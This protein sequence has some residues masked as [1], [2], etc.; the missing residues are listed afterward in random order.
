MSITNN[1]KRVVIKADQGDPYTNG[2]WQES[3]ALPEYASGDII[4]LFKV[5]KNLYPSGEGTGK[6]S[7]SECAL[8]LVYIR[9]KLGD[10]IG[11]LVFYW[12]YKDRE[13]QYFYTKYVNTG[14][15]TE[16]TAYSFVGHF[17]NEVN[18]PGILICDMAS[19]YGIV[20]FTWTIV[21]SS[22]L[23]ISLIWGPI[24]YT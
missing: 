15:Y 16:G 1:I 9:A 12:H 17:D 24:Q 3:I 10:V 6:V 11:D 21:D 8:A 2:N 7:E 19:K 13:Y 4:D 20:R 23:T 18:R 14:S 5:P 22:Q